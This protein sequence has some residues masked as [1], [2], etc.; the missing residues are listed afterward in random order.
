MSE[1]QNIDEPAS[2]DSTNAGQDDDA[3]SQNRLED[4]APEAADE[5]GFDPRAKAALAKA[6]R[7][8][9]NLRTSLRKHVKETKPLLDRLKEIEDKDKSAAE[10]QASEIAALQARLTEYEVREVRNA[11]AAAVGLPATMAQFITATDPDEAKQQAKALLEF[12]KGGAASDFK[13][14]ARTSAPQKL[15][16]DNLI[17]RMAGRQ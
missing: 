5:E 2:D 14:G 15:T 10:R 1:T 11:A 3:G 4:D 13:Q 8:A 17:R 7:E 16:G 12:R 6:R 9:L